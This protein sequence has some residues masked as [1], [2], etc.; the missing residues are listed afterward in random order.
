MCVGNIIISENIITDIHAQMWKH[1]LSNLS[2]TRLYLYIKD[3]LKFETY[4]NSIN[5]VKYRVALCRFR[6]S[7]HMLMVEKGRWV[8]PKLELHKRCCPYCKSDIEDEYHVLFIC[9]KY[10]HLR[11]LY[12]PLYT[13]TNPSV[14]KFVQLMQDTRQNVI[15]RLAKCIYLMMN[16]RKSLL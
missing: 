6:L 8:K 16:E 9:S 13:Y 15:F 4:L 10:D 2:D 14:L 12:L 11:K 1:K 5:I 3:T 7:S